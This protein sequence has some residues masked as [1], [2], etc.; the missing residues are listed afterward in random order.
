MCETKLVFCFNHRKETLPLLAIVNVVLSFVCLSITLVHP[1][2]SRGLNARW[3]A[4]YGDFGPYGTLH[5]YLGN[6]AR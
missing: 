4:K 2:Q 1:T 3:V 6:G 5:V